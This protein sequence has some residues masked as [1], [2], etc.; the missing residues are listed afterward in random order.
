MSK[1]CVY[2][3][4]FNGFD[5][6]CEEENYPLTGVFAENCYEYNELEL[7]TVP[8]QLIRDVYCYLN[9]FNESL[10]CDGTL[11]KLNEILEDSVRE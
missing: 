5:E 3:E 2:C 6:Y 11:E 10:I 1:N 4:H 7:V 8:K 9:R